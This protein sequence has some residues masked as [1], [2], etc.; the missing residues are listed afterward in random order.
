MFE[1]QTYKE[2]KEN[3]KPR[4]VPA[5][6]DDLAEDVGRDLEDDVRDVEDGVHRVEVVADKA[7][8][9][10]QPSQASVANVGPVDEAEHEDEGSQWN[11]AEIGLETDPAFHLV[12]ATI[13][14]DSRAVADHFDGALFRGIVYLG[15]HG[16]GRTMIRYKVFIDCF[17]K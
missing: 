11:D 17:S 4:E 1:D 16:D 6:A 5:G 2:A 8:I 9:P 12:V 3:G 10:F 13:S 15:R 7:E 14:R